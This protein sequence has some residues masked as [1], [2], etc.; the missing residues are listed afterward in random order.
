MDTEY[1]LDVTQIEP[2][3]KHQ[4]IFDRYFQLDSLESF[5]IENDH[6]P[7]PLHYQMLSELGNSFNWEYLERGPKHWRVRITKNSMEIPE[8]V[9]QI[10]AK[11]IRYK[12]V[13]QM[14]GIDFC[15][16]GKKSVSQA[17]LEKGINADEV[18]AAL[19]NA[20]LSKGQG[21]YDFNSWDLDFLTDYIVNIHHG[22]VKNNVELI[23]GLATKV[24]ER[25]GTQHPELIELS[26][27]VKSTLQELVQHMAKEEQIL[28]PA[29]KEINE[30]KRNPEFQSKFMPGHLQHPIKVME[31]EH[32]NAGEDL[33]DFRRIT[34]DYLLPAGACNSYQ[35]LFEKLKEFEADLMQHIHLENNILF[36]KAIEL[37]KEFITENDN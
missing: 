14:Y 9:G 32:D 29:I 8:T 28:F 13:F 18:H 7:K 3:L 35:Y 22:Y 11:D 12:D 34:K 16:G 33:A 6:D 4:V 17:C 19:K 15:C 37:D 27:V 30:R 1:I 25:H 21:S 26:N 20:A 23:L 36:P 31:H 2:K 24:S 5:V 10:A